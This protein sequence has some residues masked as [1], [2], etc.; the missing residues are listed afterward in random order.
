MGGEGKGERGGRQ[1]VSVDGS[2]TRTRV[3]GWNLECKSSF[4]QVKL[5]VPWDSHVRMFCRQLGVS[6]M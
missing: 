1:D 5:E 3:W 4:G 2:A 6:R